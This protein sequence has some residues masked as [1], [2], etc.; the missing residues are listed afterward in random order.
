MAARSKQLAAATIGDGSVHNL[1]TVPS[2]FRTIVK[3]ITV[4]NATATACGVTLE[5]KS[6]A[7]LLALFNVWTKGAG[8]D[9]DTTI[10]EPWIVL[11]AG[12]TLAVGF[13]SSGGYITVSGAELEL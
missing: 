12:Q 8:V 9:G 6:G 3:G 7:T 10:L 1:Y 13:C 4:Y 11:E 5:V 2:G